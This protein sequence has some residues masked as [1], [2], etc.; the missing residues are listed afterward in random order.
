MCVCIGGLL[1]L[2]VFQR[3][4]ISKNFGNVGGG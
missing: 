1:N 4:S 2:N 3:G